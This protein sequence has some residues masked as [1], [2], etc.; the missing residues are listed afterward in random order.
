MS[1]PCDLSVIRSGRENSLMQR[2][3]SLGV[4]VFLTSAVLSACTQASS[5][6]QPQQ[7]GEASE[8]I[9]GGSAVTSSTYAAVGA[10]VYYYPGVGVLDV[11]C[12]GTL[13]A[14]QA[15][16]TARHCTPSIDQANQSGLV[17]AFAIGPDAFNPVAVIPITNYVNAPAAPPPQAGLLQDGGR[18]V[19]VVHLASAPAGVTPVQL[20]VFQDTFVGSKFDI[21]GFGVTSTQFVAGQQFMGK[22]TARAESGAWYPLL[23]NGNY[24]AFHSWYF[25]DSSG[26][27]RT[28]AEA[29][30]W[31]KT[32]K[33]ENKYELLAGGLKGE[34]VACFGDSG[35]PLLRGTT[36]ATLTTYGVSFAVE[37]TISSACGL[38]GGYLIFNKQML[39]FVKS[40]I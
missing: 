33:L 26:A 3:S 4:V 22:A 16:T 17:P 29:K 35:G 7:L 14:P 36:P 30:T 1:F 32:Y 13:V 18:D 39:A 21:V 8:A 10:L 2:T 9:I 20:G 40:A 34:A 5:T 24:D 27:Q 15:I 28:E 37:G 38:G 12:S 25:S 6:A 11:F 23:F 19:A 31:W